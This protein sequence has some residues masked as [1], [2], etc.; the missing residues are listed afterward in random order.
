MQHS[1]RRSNIDKVF[2][3]EIVRPTGS[4]F[5]KGTKEKLLKS[6]SSALHP[7]LHR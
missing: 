6:Y 2:Q 5:L 4:S 1:Y 3:A 7:E